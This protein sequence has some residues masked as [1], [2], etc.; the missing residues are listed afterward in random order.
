MRS[1]TLLLIRMKAAETSASSAIA[2]CTPLAV[3]WRSSMTAEMDTFINDVSTTR[4]NIAIDSRI[5]SR[6][7]PWTG[8]SAV[9]PR[10]FAPTGA[11]ASPCVDEFE[12]GQCRA[13]T[14]LPA[15]QVDLVRLDDLVAVHDVHPLVQRD[16]GIDVRGL[17]P[18]QVTDGE[19]RAVLGEDRVLVRAVPDG[20]AGDG[21][22]AV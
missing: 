6:R 17:G 8:A 11:A 1:P 18:V 4:T 21:R 19:R 20:A 12:A 14:R 13:K 3:V 22:V 15:A 7:L 16:G 10:R 2:D 9:T 5:I